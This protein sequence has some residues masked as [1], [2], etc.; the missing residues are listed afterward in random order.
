MG[1]S[2]LDIENNYRILSLR[3]FGILGRISIFKLLT[4]KAKGWYCPQQM[5]FLAKSP[6]TGGK[7]QTPSLE[8]NEENIRAYWGSLMTEVKRKTFEALL[9]ETPGLW[10]KI[11]DWHA[12]VKKAGHLAEK[13]QVA[14]IRSYIEGTLPPEEQEILR[15]W[16]ARDSSFRSEVQA[17]EKFDKLTKQRGEAD[18]CSKKLKPVGGLTV[19]VETLQKIHFRTSLVARY[20]GSLLYA[21]EKNEILE[22]AVNKDLF[23]KKLIELVKIRLQG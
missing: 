9:K 5:S 21:E 4:N 17:R 20:L 7:D 8:V 13:E 23:A 6:G 14:Y 15:D 3:T 22:T 2:Y 16:C 1:I 18:Y 12:Y 10:K 11:Q 19:T